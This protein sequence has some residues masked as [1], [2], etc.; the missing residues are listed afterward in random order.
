MAVL[1]LLQEIQTAVP[2]S[3]LAQLTNSELPANPN[4]VAVAGTIAVV[5]GSANIVGTGTA[6]TGLTVGNVLAF[7]PQQGV[8]YTLQAVTDDTHAALAVAYTGAS[9]AAATALTAG[10]NYTNL[11][12]ACNQAAVEFMAATGLQWDNVTVTDV[13]QVPPIY[14]K[15]T[16]CG[17]LLTL[18]RLYQWAGMVELAEKLKAEAAE[19]VDYVLHT[20]GN[21]AWAP[22]ASD[23]VYTPTIGPPR[24]PAFDTARLGQFLLDNPGIGLGWGGGAGGGIPTE[25]GG[26]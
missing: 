19:A 4:V 21:G 7:S 22:P 13:T 12:Q 11:T 18:K 1:L 24:P 5:N 2:T 9:A 6:F 15:C 20:W 25:Y 8:N 3:R 17:I 10:I 26:P 23:S 16:W 14:N